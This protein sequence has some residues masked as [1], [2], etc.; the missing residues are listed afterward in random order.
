MTRGF[1][2]CFKNYTKHGQTTGNAKGGLKMGQG[3]EN[4]S[5][6][7][8]G[9]ALGFGVG[10]E[11]GVKVGKRGQTPHFVVPEGGAFEPS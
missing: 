8:M 6:L 3:T 11:N 1:C 9:Q 4:G 5:G 10:R 7:K 2:M